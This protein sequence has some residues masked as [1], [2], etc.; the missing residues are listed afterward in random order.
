MRRCTY[1]NTTTRFHLANPRN[2]PPK[3]PPDKRTEWHAKNIMQPGH[4]TA[5]GNLH[6]ELPSFTEMPDPVGCG[7]TEP[8]NRNKAG[9]FVKGNT[10]GKTKRLRP[11]LGG[12][13]VGEG[14]DPVYKKFAKWGRKYANQR[15][16]ELAIA[17][18]GK[19]SA[20]VGAMVES[21]ALILTNARYIQWLAS[22]LRGDPKEAAGLLKTSAQLST[23]A[24][25]QE[26]AAWWLADREARVRPQV[27]PHTDLFASLE[28]TG[29]AMPEVPPTPILPESNNE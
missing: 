1:A 2:T 15:R 23:E 3:A 6:V 19:I 22:G 5:R 25:Q 13:A 8:L 7:D 26:A 16:L 4:G 20:G 14:A 11:N 18:G 10:A 27:N 24:R 17:H 9:K 21:A 12:G 29:S 28:T